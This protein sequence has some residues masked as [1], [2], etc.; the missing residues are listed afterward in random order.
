MLNHFDT[1]AVMGLIAPRPFLVLTGDCDAGSPLSGIKVLEN[2]LQ[3]VYRLY[4][5]EENF[6]SIVYEKTGHVFTDEMK[7]EMI[8]WLIK[9]LKN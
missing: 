5:K 3:S 2:K 9:H 8:N 7:I 1:E 4:D 6:N